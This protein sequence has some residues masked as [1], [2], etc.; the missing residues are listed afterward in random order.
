MFER[1]L[2]SNPSG[3]ERFLEMIKLQLDYLILGVVPTTTLSKKVE[4]V[5]W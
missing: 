3:R 2:A 1:I 5:L 4:L